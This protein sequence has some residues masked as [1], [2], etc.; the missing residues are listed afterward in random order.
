[1]LTPLLLIGIALVENQLTAAGRTDL[2]S[3]NSSSTVPFLAAELT[4]WAVGVVLTFR[5]PRHGV[6]WLFLGLATSI[7]AGGFF[8]SFANLALRAEP[9]GWPLGGTA[10]VLGDSIFV[11]W[12]L[13]VALILQLT[14]TGRPLSPRLW[15]LARLTVLSAGGFEVAAFLR[16][17][18]I[19]GENAGLVSPLAVKSLAGPLAVVAS[20]AILVLCSC[21]LASV[22]VLVLRF[23]RSQGVERQ[24]M[25]WLVVGV[26]P[27]PIC[28]VGSFLAAYAHYE[29]LAGGAISVGIAALAV[30][31]GFSV[32]KYRLYDVERVLS[33]A[34]AY[35]IASASVISIYGGVTF[36][37]TRSIPIES[38]STLTTIASTLAAAAVALPGYRWARTGIDR[39]FN[40]RRFDA[41]RLVRAGLTEDNPDLERLV[42]LALGDPNARILFTA[43]GGEAT[44]VSTGGQPVLPGTNVVDVVRRRAVTAKIE[45]DPLRTERSVVEAIARE[46]A[47]EIDNLGLLAKLGW[48]L[49]EVSNSRSR[50]AGAHLAE[51]RRMERDL[52]DGAQQRLLA[53]ALQIQ[54]ARVNGSDELLRDEADRAVIDLGLAVQELRDLA[55]GQQPASLAGGGL[56]AAVDELA[57]RIPI[58]LITDI[59]DERFDA[60]IEGAAW[61]VIAEGV[62]NAVKHAVVDTI[63]IVIKHE[64]G[65]VRVSVSD[66]GAGGANNHGP[67]L[68]GLSDRV[69]AL[70]GTFAVR[71]LQPSG[72]RIEAEIP[73]G[74]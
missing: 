52:H 28:V 67:G 55:H 27:L 11:W 44:W 41:V 22:V 45:F 54:S 19:E 10:A 32:A 34:G 57:G 20:A 4:C 63:Q 13:F 39:R 15:W 1:M 69:A 43:E 35:G 48:Q 64:R 73:C 30:G 24:Q 17:T 56:S 7:G 2:V 31:A 74:L 29:T 38:G 37:L 49:R 61:F 46:A 21:L 40:R 51:R 18:P 59:V 8:D 66:A 62:S 42:A 33:D 65:A 71:D 16:S 9:D 14:P 53:I 68:Q 47:A 12:F 6:G 26:A 5:V 23:R 36:V 70:G 25:L 60:G 3:W 50:L 58:R 72:T